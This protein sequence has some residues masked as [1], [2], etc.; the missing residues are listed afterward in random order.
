MNTEPPSHGSA[1]V[2][3]CGDLKGE[4][5]IEPGMRLVCVFS[6]TCD[7]IPKSV[8]DNTGIFQYSL[9]SPLMESRLYFYRQMN[10]IL[11]H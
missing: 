8:S 6:C 2:F 10:K 3:S 1:S 5:K 11:I 9:F 4:E 7:L